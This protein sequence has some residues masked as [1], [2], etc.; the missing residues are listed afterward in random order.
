MNLKPRDIYFEAALGFALESGAKLEHGQS[1]LD[2]TSIQ[3]KMNVD[4]TNYFIYFAKNTDGSTYLGI[5]DADEM[6][7]NFLKRIMPKL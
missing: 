7:K 3:F 1:K 4:D 6:Q 5:T 2:T